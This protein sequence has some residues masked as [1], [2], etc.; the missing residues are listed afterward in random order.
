MRHSDAEVAGKH[1]GA[2]GEVE[3]MGIS[4][5]EAMAMQLMDETCQR[6]SYRRSDK[7]SPQRAG[8][9]GSEKP[10][11]TNHSTQIARPCTTLPS[12]NRIA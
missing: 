12:S 5:D 11:G 6:P 10:L 9:D 3:E 1:F 7:A 4:G 8:L 2:V